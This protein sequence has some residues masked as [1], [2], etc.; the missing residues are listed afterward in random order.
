MSPYSLTHSVPSSFGT[1]MPRPALH[2]SVFQPG[3][4]LFFL[5]WL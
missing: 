5:M 4:C 1:T 2:P 3:G